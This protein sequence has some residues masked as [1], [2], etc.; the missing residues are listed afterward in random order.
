MNIA[1]ITHPAF[2]NYGGILQAYALQT[3]LQRLGHEVKKVEFPF[4]YYHPRMTLGHRLASICKQSLKRY[5]ARQSHTIIDLDGY[6]Y[7]KSKEAM[8]HTRTFVEEHINSLIVNDLSEIRGKFDCFVSGSDQVWRYYGYD[9]ALLHYFLDFTKND[10]VK[11]IG[12]AVSFGKNKADYPQALQEKC[13]ALAKKFDAIS[14][15]EDSGIDICKNEFDV[16]AIKV[17]DPTLLLS[18][19]D[20]IALLGKEIKPKHHIACYILDESKEKTQMLETASKTFSIPLLYLNAL[21]DP[22]N[23]YFDWRVQPSVESWLE[24]IATSDCVITDSFH[25]CVFSIIF[26]KPFWAI[27]N[28]ERG[29]DRFLSL[30]KMFDL[31]DRLITDKDFK[32]S[33]SNNIDWE[34]VNQRMVILQQESRNF[35]IN[36]LSK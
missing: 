21:S 18:S 27:A 35:L 14:V 17:L 13:K 24:G 29:L 15:R 36:E 9:Q 30:L 22:P 33:L 20:Y 10:N 25:G 26:N 31:E 7:K 6:G 11:R 23:E 3:I 2:T 5:I 32:F 4:D 34:H 12:Y 19:A 28:K 16:Y 8:V 1:I